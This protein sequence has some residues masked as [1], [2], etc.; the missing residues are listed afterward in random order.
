MLVAIVRFSSQ[1]GAKEFL[2]LSRYELTCLRCPMLLLCIGGI[3]N[4]RF[5]A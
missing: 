2:I 5:G 3:E 4:S 1:Y